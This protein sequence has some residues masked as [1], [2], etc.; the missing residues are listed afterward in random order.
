MEGIYFLLLNFNE[1]RC[2]KGNSEK[3]TNL[4]KYGFPH[5]KIH[6]SNLPAHVDGFPDVVFLFVPRTEMNIQEIEHVKKKWPDATLFGILCDHSTTLIA[7]YRTSLATVDDFLCCPVTPVDIHL[8]ILKH[9]KTRKLVSQAPP[10]N[11]QENPYARDGLIGESVSFCKA[12]E[13]ITV[14]AKT[15]A[16]ILI[17]GETGT[18]KELVAR[19]IHYHGPR[20]GKPFIPVNCGALPDHLFENELFGHV[21]GAYTDASS[22]HTGLIHEAEGGTLFLDEIDTLSLPAQAKLLRFLED[23][24][25]RPLG[26]SKT[27]KANVRILTATNKDLQCLVQSKDFREDLFYRIHIFPLRIP[28]LRERP[29]DIPLLANHFL[30]KAMKVL[31]RQ[32]MHLVSEVRAK[33]AAY[34]WPGNVRELDAVI[35]RAVMYSPTQ[36]IEGKAIDLPLPDQTVFG[37]NGNFFGQAKKRV[38]EHFERNYLIGLLT[39]Y[40]GNITQAA[41]AAGK[42]RRSFQ[43]LL[44]K[45][46]LNRTSFL[47]NPRL[48]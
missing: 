19:A 7:K 48:S 20:K 18:G 36:T 35:H 38:L 40:H 3:L 33:L 26:A 2:P 25:Y 11:H 12:V 1:W 16:P 30:T 34:H 27:S 4:I 17:S 28:P 37:K 8:R 44:R 14:L 45:H 24:E 10:L 43:R 5:A 21:R 29:E 39:T 32:E 13:K 41:K 42:E 22:E 31:G 47:E 9:L 46:N 23:Q 6:L 15:E